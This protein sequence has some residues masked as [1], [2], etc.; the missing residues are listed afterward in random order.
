MVLCRV[1]QYTS[2]DGGGFSGLILRFDLLQL[3]GICV[4][5]LESE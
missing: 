1:L 4:E 3:A 5:V 2:W